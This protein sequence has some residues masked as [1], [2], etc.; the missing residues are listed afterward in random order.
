MTVRPATEQDL[1]AILDIY[2]DV[3]LNTTAV[4]SYEP[5]TL[6]MR[7]EWFDARMAQGFPIIVT[8]EENEI[9]GFGSFG[10]FRV[11]PAYL[12]TVENSVYVK[13]T[14]RGKGIGRILLQHLI[15]EAKKL[16]LHTMIAG[17]DA[18]NEASIALHKKFGFEQAAY[19][20]QVGFKFNRWLDLVFMQLML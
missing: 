4:Y 18:S 9:T 11:W 7:K 15:D 1:P 12:H 16:H 3:I 6:H 17:I 13:T 20:K 5:H 10:S 14:A 2:N 8:E 19:F